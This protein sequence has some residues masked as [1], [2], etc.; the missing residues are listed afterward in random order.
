[1]EKI[2][3]LGGPK[4]L[5]RPTMNSAEEDKDQILD[6]GISSADFE[7]ENVLE[8]IFAEDFREKEEEE[9]ILG[10]EIDQLEVEE[11]HNF[12]NGEDSDDETEIEDSHNDEMQMS[13]PKKEESKWKKIRKWS[14]GC[15]VLSFLILGII[16][17]VDIIL[18]SIADAKFDTETVNFYL[19]SDNSDAKCVVRGNYPTHSTF[20]AYDLVHPKCVV[21]YSNSGSSLSKLHYLT[22]VGISA[23]RVGS[24]SSS[25][26]GFAG[27]G[28][29]YNEPIKITIDLKNTEY[30]NFDLF[31]Q[32]VFNIDTKDSFFHVNCH[33]DLEI[34][35]L[36][37]FPVVARDIKV[38]RWFPLHLH[39]HHTN[40]TTKTKNSSP[41]SST[42]TATK[43]S[44]ETKSDSGWKLPK[45]ITRQDPPKLSV[46]SSSSSKLEVGVGWDFKNFI[47][48]AKSAPDV[49][50]HVPKISYSISTVGN[51]DIRWN[52][53]SSPLQFELTRSHFYLETNFTLETRDRTSLESKLPLVSPDD[54]SNFLDRLSNQKVDIVWDAETDNFL[55][56]LL[57]L[58]HHVGVSNITDESFPG[59]S[60]CRGLT[61]NYNGN[62]TFD[63]V[64]C[65]VHDPS[66]NEKLW[67]MMILDGDIDL[68]NMRSLNT[69]S[70]MKEK[71]LMSGEFKVS[72]QTTENLNETEVAMVFRMRDGVVEGSLGGIWS[73]ENNLEDGSGVNVSTSVSMLLKAKDSSPFELNSHSHVYI[74]G[75]ELLFDSETSWL[76]NNISDSFEIDIEIYSNDTIFEGELNCKA[77]L[78]SIGSAVVLGDYNLLDTHHW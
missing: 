50:I 12:A 62:T 4:D 15:M 73:S 45:S 17:A 70:F 55:T 53:D 74:E 2:E 36:D 10:A 24:T 18:F 40:S 58:N 29:V 5:T 14:C 64:G 65:S 44:T 27:L 71:S 54:I 38:S 21:G 39:R 66:D 30:G 76:L 32:D 46:F 28:A 56:R 57:G 37:Y 16:I 63:A 68:D 22:T 60:D 11:N 67:R 9:E 77:D 78:G 48:F 7:S 26:T 34:K 8:Y 75:K 35:F 61:M 33:T 1:M 43:K 25:S 13:T 3:S 52:S 20:S 59:A 42:T 51:N 19:E 31:L 72:S 49:F 6:S 23:Q 41:E 47:K 69:S